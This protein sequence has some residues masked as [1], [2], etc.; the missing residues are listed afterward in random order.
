[1]GLASD[2]LG[3]TRIPAH[4]CGVAGLKASHGRIPLTSSVFA[5]VG[6]IARLRS[7]G[8]VARRVED[9]GAGLRILS[10]PDG[11]DPWAAPVPLGDPAAV[12]VASLRVAVHEDNG[13][14]SP[15]PETAEA[16]RRAAEAL[17]AAGARV[18]EARPSVID[19]TATVLQ[20][21][22]GDG[23]AELR[24]TLDVVGTRNDEISPLVRSLMAFSGGSI[25]AG[26]EIAALQRWWDEFRLA[27]L[28]F[29]R[30]YD[31]VLCPVA[32]GPAVEHG[33]SFEHLLAFSN[34]WTFNL[35]GWPAAVVRVGSSPEGLPIG[36][37]VAAG[38]WRDHV[39]LAAAAVIEQKSGGW[40]PPIL[41][42]E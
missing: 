22:G 4:F 5:T 32:A 8:L 10:G 27:M 14:A 9:L 12:D 1:L 24:H 3:S 20:L 41:E 6:P 13:I 15:S 42:T 26:N 30:R 38:P 21:F 39:A 37:Q 7:I 35:T 16:V 40:E 36:I 23:G 28:A 19:Q 31:V 17:S 11:H 2:S 34:A 18:E 29:L 25:K 33:A